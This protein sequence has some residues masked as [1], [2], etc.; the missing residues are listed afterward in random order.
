MN[1]L[2]HYL[3]GDHNRCDDLFAETENTVADGDWAKAP[4]A[5]MAF[6]KAMLRHFALEDALL[7]PLFEERTGMASGPTMVMRSEHAQMTGV[8]EAMSQAL[9]NRAGNDYLGHAETLLMLMRQHNIKEEQI[10]YPM[11]D[12]VMSDEEDSLL[13]RMEHVS[14]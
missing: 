11:I 12:R 1:R 7:F 14:A 9:E 8:L 13:S 5:F 3:T 4:A 6:R 2:S 10:L